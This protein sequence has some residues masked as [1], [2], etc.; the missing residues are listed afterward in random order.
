M[1]SA[2]AGLRGRRSG[3]G[4]GLGEPFR[5]GAGDG[6]RAAAQAGFAARAGRP[7]QVNLM[8]AGGPVAGIATGRP[9]QGERA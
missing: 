9:G 2:F 4:H 1:M 6:C 7:G 3:L 8:D 5:A